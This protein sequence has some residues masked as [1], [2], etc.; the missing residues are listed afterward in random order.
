MFKDN[1]KIFNDITYLFTISFSKN[2]LAFGI[3][4]SKAVIVIKIF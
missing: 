2:K 1:S 3:P 4:S